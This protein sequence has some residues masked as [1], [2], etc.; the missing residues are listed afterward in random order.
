MYKKK[1]PRSNLNN[2]IGLKKFDRTE[3]ETRDSAALLKSFILQG[4]S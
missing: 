4:K 2:V 1:Q 3:G